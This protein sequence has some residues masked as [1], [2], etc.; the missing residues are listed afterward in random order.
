MQTSVNKK[1]ELESQEIWAKR[2]KQRED[3]RKLADSES[4]EESSSE[5]EGEGEEE[6]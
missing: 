2:K 3:L 6:K 4:E 1:V 5:S